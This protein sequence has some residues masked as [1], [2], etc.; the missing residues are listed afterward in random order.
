MT[1]S[2]FI[3]LD[4]KTIKEFLDNSFRPGEDIKEI[5]R[6]IVPRSFYSKSEDWPKIYKGL[7]ISVEHSRVIILQYLDL[8]VEFKINEKEGVVAFLEKY[9]RNSEDWFELIDSY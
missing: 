6:R 9:S 7:M 2:E 4:L 3:D 8:L 5:V 1:P